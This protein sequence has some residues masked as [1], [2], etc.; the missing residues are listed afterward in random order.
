MVYA[1]AA[2]ARKPE[3][4]ESKLKR[5]G[6]RLAIPGRAGDCHADC[7]ISILKRLVGVHQPNCQRSGGTL[8]VPSA[9][10]ANQAP[11]AKGH[12]SSG[13]HGVNSRAGFFF[14]TFQAPKSVRKISASGGIVTAYESLPVPRLNPILYQATTSRKNSHSGHFRWEFSSDS[15]FPAH[16]HPKSKF[17]NWPPC[18]P[19]PI[20]LG[21]L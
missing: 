15:L 17:R 8:S 18:S 19:L 3:Q 14:K 12:L 7:R 4:H 21:D 5:S 16:R 10:G 2:R 9:W 1:Y 20:P 11:R 6:S 13:L